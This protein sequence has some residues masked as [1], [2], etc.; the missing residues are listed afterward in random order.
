MS[1]VTYPGQLVQVDENPSGVVLHQLR[2]TQGHIGVPST[3]IR[4]GTHYL[5][6]VPA[7]GGEEGQGGEE[8]G[9]HHPPHPG[10]LLV[11]QQTAGLHVAPGLLVLGVTGVTGA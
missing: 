6:L 5:L 8:R 10:S 7:A 3:S 1:G 11:P 9:Q 4:V 2:Q